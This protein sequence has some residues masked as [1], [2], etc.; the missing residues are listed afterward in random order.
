MVKI[1]TFLLAMLLLPAA[2]GKTFDGLEIKKIATVDDGI[3]STNGYG[4]Y[5]YLLEN[6]ADV[7]RQVRLEIT[8]SS[9]SY[10]L[11]LSSLGQTVTVPPRATVRT[12][13]YRPMASMFNPQLSIYIDGHYFNGNIAG[14]G[15]EPVYHRYRNSIMV[16]ASQGISVNSWGKGGKSKSGYDEVKMVQATIPMTQW[17]DNRLAYTSFAA[18]ILTAQEL[19]RAPETIRN[20]LDQYVRLGNT[21]IVVDEKPLSGQAGG[22]D[23]RQSNIC[24]FGRVTYL[25]IALKKMTEEQWDHLTVEVKDTALAVRGGK[26]TDNIDEINRSYPVMAETKIPVKQLFVLLLVFVIIIGPINFIVLSR[27]KKL[28]WILW[29]TPLL[30]LFFSGLVVVYSLLSE[31]WHS[32]VRVSTLT[33]LDEGKQQAY[34]LGIHG[35]YCPIAP[36]SG[37]RYSHAAELIPL[38]P[39]KR[40]VGMEWDSDQHMTYGWVPSRVPTFFALRQ[41]ESR[42]ERLK[43]AT[44]NSKVVVTNGLGAKILSLQ[45]VMSDGQIFNAVEP[46]E[47]GAA[48]TLKWSGNRIKDTPSTQEPRSVRRSFVPRS[49]QL[50][51]FFIGNWSSSLSDE[52]IAH[53]AVAPGGY[54]AKLEHSPFVTP[55]L[56]PGELNE[57]CLVI[58]RS[59]LK[60]EGK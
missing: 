40:D 18:I 13:L 19:E 38:A 57:S 27:R 17:S 56:K 10:H 35:Y 53:A 37:L 25:K 30:S 47:P 52:H 44:V 8:S 15:V 4:E 9:K 14:L 16:L 23:Y 32:R 50:R 20:V 58:G 12:R 60:G 39:G 28:I 43:I 49:S 36:R 51:S 5:E 7:A 6:R 55:G 21:L 11:S 45:V 31:G 2:F 42:K 1:W 41:A 46:I 59:E 34:T 3:S 22:T 29:T 26:Q 33:L 54:C 24:D 48:A